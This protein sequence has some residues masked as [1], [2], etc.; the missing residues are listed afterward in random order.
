LVFEVFGRF[1]AQ[2]SGFYVTCGVW[3]TI[4]I[5]RAVNVGAIVAFFEMDR[6]LG[7]I[8]ALIARTSRMAVCHFCLYPVL[9]FCVAV[10]K[11]YT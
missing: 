7:P 11:R 1:F 9:R 5:A 6:G 10:L 8:C 2:T 3:P 4:H